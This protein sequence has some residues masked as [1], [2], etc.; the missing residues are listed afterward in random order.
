MDVGVACGADHEGFAS[1]LGHDSHPFGL[2]GRPGLSRSER[3]RIWCTCTVS[4]C[5][6]T[7]HRPFRSRRSA[8]GGGLVARTGSR[9]VQDRVLL[10]YERDT[11]EPCDQWLA[12]LAALDNDLQAL[13][14]PVRC[15]DVAAYLRVIL[16]T[17]ES[18]LQASVLSSEVCITQFSRSSRQTSPANR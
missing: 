15:L 13:A 8:L 7:S 3:L 10:P 6:Q 12:S 14:W 11:T 9:S 18:Y 5:P 17:D 16:S 1:P 4:A 2:F